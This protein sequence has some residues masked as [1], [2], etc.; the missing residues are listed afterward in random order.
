[1]LVPVDWDTYPHMSKRPIRI[2]L[3]VLF[4]MALAQ[5]VWG[6]EGYAGRT[7]AI[8]VGCF[9]SVPKQTFYFDE[10]PSGHFQVSEEQ[11]EAHLGPLKRFKRS[12]HIFLLRSSNYGPCLKKQYYTSL[13]E[14][15]EA[16]DVQHIHRTYY[17]SDYLIRPAYYAFLFRLSPF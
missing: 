1:M 11:S 3:L 15:F 14:S 4:L 8:S 13:Q 9:L 12:R 7:D 5:S 16:G 10:H 6:H 2:Y 17:N